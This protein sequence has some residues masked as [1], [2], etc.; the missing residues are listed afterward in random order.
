[1]LAPVAADFT[2]SASPSILT[3]LPGGSVQ[4]SIT[5]TPAGSFSGSVKLSVT[6]APASL[7]ALFA[8]A[9]TTGSRLTL[10]AGSQA[11][12]DTYVIGVPARLNRLVTS[13]PLASKFLL[14]HLQR[15][16]TPL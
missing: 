14:P 2:L 6:G 8:A 4:M 9:G 10:S 13:A 3:M 12:P 16:H 11:K 15:T 5:I 7:T 1:M